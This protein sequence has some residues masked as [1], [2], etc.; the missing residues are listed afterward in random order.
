MNLNLYNT[1]SINKT[2]LKI[3]GPI[4]TIYWSQLMEILPKVFNKKT[5]N[6]EGY[7]LLD[8]DY[9]ERQI[10]LSRA[11]QYNCD[12]S[13]G[14]IGV[15]EISADNKDLIRVNSTLMTSIIINEDIEKIQAIVDKLKL[16]SSTKSANKKYANEVQKKINKEI[17]EKE[18]DERKS[19]KLKGYIRNTRRK[20]EEYVEDP[21]LLDLFSSWAESVCTRYGFISNAIVEK[22]Y[23]ELTTYTQNPD[24]I[25]VLLD[26]GIKTGYR[27]FDYVKSYY[28]DKFKPRTL[29]GVSTQIQPISKG[30]TDKT[31]YF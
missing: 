10:G 29:G 8:R 13:L 16:D 30:K 3:V 9:I 17:K 21:N 20:L 1:M 6:E 4:T 7:F 23:K 19:E 27:D 25:Q 28:E 11:D 15:V 14:Q 2:L 24:Q 22:F 26:L 31:E 5:Y 18:S 12:S